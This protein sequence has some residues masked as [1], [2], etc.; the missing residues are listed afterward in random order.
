M[1]VEVAE[2]NTKL[3]ILHT[4]KQ[5]VHTLCYWGRNAKMKICFCVFFGLLW[6]F[7]FWG[8]GIVKE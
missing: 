1:G 5:A 7:S 6:L 4:I 8:V 2:S 3:C